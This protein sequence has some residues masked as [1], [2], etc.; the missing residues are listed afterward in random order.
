VLFGFLQSNGVP[1]AYIEVATGITLDVSLA[2]LCSQTRTALTPCTTLGCA[3]FLP[4]LSFVS[5]CHGVC[6]QD[7]GMAHVDVYLF[8]CYSCGNPASQGATHHAVLAGVNMD[9]RMIVSRCCL[10][11]LFGNSAT[12]DLVLAKLQYHEQLPVWSPTHVRP[13]VVRHRGPGLLEW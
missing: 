13:V 4:S 11:C 12:V 2:Y 1:G 3:K 10:P 7:G 5:L 9:R 8:P 6:E